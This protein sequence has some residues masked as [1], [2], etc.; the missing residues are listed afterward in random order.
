MF[1]SCVVR[2]LRSARSVLFGEGKLAASFGEGIL[3]ASHGEGILAAS[4]RC[5]LGGGNLAEDCSKLG[6]S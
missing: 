6:F 4:R 1:E 5:K 3:A 2:N